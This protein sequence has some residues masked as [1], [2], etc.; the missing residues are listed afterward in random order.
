ME[1]FAEI[2]VV[3]LLFVIGLELSLDRLRELRRAFLVGG[4]VQSA[5]TAAIAVAAS[6]ALGLTLDRAVFLGFVFA[7]SSTAIVLKLYGD[8]RETDTPHGRMVLGI[9]LFQDFLIVPMIVLVPVL[10]GEVGAS[11]LEL[12]LR[13]GGSLVAIAAIVVASRPSSPPGSSI[14]SPAP[15]LARPSSSARWGSVWCSPG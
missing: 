3:L 4:S 12:L 1:V 5:V 15:G 10:A 8:R 9:L 2:G 6:L 13:F 14:G 11:P 7:L